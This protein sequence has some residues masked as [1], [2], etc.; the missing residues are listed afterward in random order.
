MLEDKGCQGNPC[1][2]LPVLVS[3][4]LLQGT[5]WVPG[6][7]EPGAELEATEQGER[8]KGESQGLPCSVSLCWHPRH[9]AGRAESRVL[10][11]LE[12]QWENDNR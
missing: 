11:D 9:P 4:I 5:G 1:P 6:T 3:V 10:G 12:S 2:S 8:K 7:A